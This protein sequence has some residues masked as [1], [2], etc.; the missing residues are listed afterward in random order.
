MKRRKKEILVALAGNPNTGKTT[1]FNQLTGSRQHTGNW[2]GVTVEKKEG[3]FS[4]HG[5]KVK[6]VDLPGTYGL[7]AYSIDEKIARDFVVKEKPNVVVAIVDA[8]NLERNLYLV[9]Q[10]LELEVNLVICLNM[11]DMAQRGGWEIDIRTL[12]DV[13][14]SP[15]VPTVANKGEGIEELKKAI[16]SAAASTDNKFRINYGKDAE[17]MIEEVEEKLRSLGEIPY[18]DRWSAIKFLEG[19]PEVTKTLLKK[20]IDQKGLERFLRKVQR[21]LGYDDLETLIAERRYGYIHGVCKE[22]IKKR[23]GIEERINWSDQIDKV[24]TNKYLG[25]EPGR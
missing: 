18:P 1:V 14:N 22:C 23:A 3:E 10:L 15:V 12:S 4:L 7:T 2:P 17:A 13:M 11:M 5:T 6:V 16:L 9:T 21:D 19:D 25:M 8:S 20:G 24:L